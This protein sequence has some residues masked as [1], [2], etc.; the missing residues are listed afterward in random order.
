MR[1]TIF[2]KQPHLRY[3]QIEAILEKID[4]EITEIQLPAWRPGRY[5]LGNFAKNVRN[6]TIT[7]EKGQPV[8]FMK[9]TKDLWQV[10]TAESKNLIIQYEYFAATLDAGSTYTGEDILYVNPVN[11]L[12]YE[13]Q[14]IESPC[15]LTL[16][17]PDNFTI[18]CALPLEGKTLKAE[19]FDQLADSPIIASPTV[20]HYA[21]DVDGI[22]QH[23]WINGHHT[24][25]VQRFLTQVK[26]YTQEQAAIFKHFPTTGYHYLIHMLPGSFRHGV[27][28]CHSTVIAIGP[29]SEFYTP[30]KHNDLLAI[31]SHELFHFWNIKR[32]RPAVMVPY[33]LTGENYSTLGYVYEGV[34]TYYGDYMLLRSGVNS[35]DNYAHEFSKDLLRHFENEGRYNYSVAESSYD[36]WLDGYTPGTPGRKVSIYVE[37][38]LAALIADI[39]V[40][41]AT[42]NK[43]SLDT[44]MKL[45][46]DRC[47]IAGNGYTEDDYQAALEEVSGLDMTKYFEDFIWGKGNIEK[48]LPAI[49]DKIGLELYSTPTPILHEGLYGFKTAKVGDHYIITAIAHGSPA[50]LAGIHLGATIATINNIPYT[51][52]VSLDAIIAESEGNRISLTLQSVHHTQ[53]VLL[54][55]HQTAQYHS[56]YGVRKQADATQQ[57]KDFYTQWSKQAF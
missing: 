51:L 11:C 47:F 5:E 8:P 3:I 6:F 7:N 34:T 53:T 54:A 26:L 17:I 33:N 46:Y 55:P 40:R 4:A 48:Q 50:D 2:H 24:L 52:D 44:V 42:N 30:E 19:S 14:S 43:S 20:E 41:E 28:H 39:T 13:T 57:Q 10:Q 49:L 12:V 15:Q 25:D 1:Y 21:V 36:T 38:M 27:E 9:I 23:V 31:C 18:A 16:D 22:T 37:G 35:F 29:G 45:L 32:L 56:V